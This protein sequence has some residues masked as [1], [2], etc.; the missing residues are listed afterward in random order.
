MFT[1]VSVLF[2]A[3]LVF[4]FFKWHQERKARL[5]LEEALRAGEAQWST[6]EASLLTDEFVSI[7]SH[8]LRTQ[9]TP[10]LGAAYMLRT[11]RHDAGILQRCL[12]LIERNAK[13]QSKIIEDLLEVSCIL[14]GKLRLNTENVELETVV[15][16]AVETIRPA[17]E[18]KNIQIQ[19]DL[20]RLSGVVFGDGVRLQQVVGNLLSNSV[21]FTP[22][23]GAIAVE[24]D[25]ID[26][27]AELR[28]KDTGIGISPD[29][30]PHVFDRFRQAD[31][32]RTHTQGGLGLGMCIVRHLVESHGGTVRACSLGSHQGSTITVRLPLHS[33]PQNSRSA[34]DPPVDSMS[35]MRRTS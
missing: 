35:S 1:S 18:A 31:A 7:L 28:V 14:N 11:E 27:C 19:L 17:S 23:G 34:H 13:A 15:Q 25:E 30:L 5:R 26:S 2:A 16:A 12:D 33:V 29:S 20:R 24:L 8:E 32:S 22:R 4:A 21:K 6:Q 10:I 9:L 3:I